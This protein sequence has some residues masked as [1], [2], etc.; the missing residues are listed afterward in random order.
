M[1]LPLGSLG[2]SLFDLH[3]GLDE[4]ILRSLLVFIFLAVALRLGGKRELS[5]INVLDLAVLLLASNALQ[6][7]LIG[8]DSTVTGGVIGA[9]TLFV[10]N[11]VFVRLTYRSARARRILEGTPTVLLRNG[12]P[13]EKAMR[14][15]AI[16][17]AEL[18]DIALQHGFSDLHNV[19]LIVIETSGQFVCLGQEQARK[20]RPE[21]LEQPG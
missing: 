5:Q 7:A 6:N 8:N 20:L 16:S 14:R 2:G 9:G 13:E 21:M 11:Y 10:A 17:M 18:A 19:G 15:E 4:K 1:D 12:E 3:L